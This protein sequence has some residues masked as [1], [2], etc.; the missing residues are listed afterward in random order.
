MTSS[1]LAIGVEEEVSAEILE[2]TASH[3]V[4]Q[5]WPWVNQAGLLFMPSEQPELIHH[6]TPLTVSPKL[7]LEIA[8]QLFKRMGWVFT[9][10]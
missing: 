2:T 9:A 7:P 1:G 10:V 5:I 8:M 3:D 4:L 6:Q